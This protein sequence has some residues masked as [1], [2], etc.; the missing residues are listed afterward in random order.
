MSKKLYLIRHAKSS[1][2]DPS[3][4]D[5]DRPLNK[6]GKRDAPF[7][8][9]ILKE[10]NILPDIMISSTAERAIEFAKVLAEELDYRKKDILADKEM[11]MAGESEML[12]ILQRVDDKN[13]T[14]FMVGHNPYITSF[15]VRLSGYPIDNIPT[16][17]IVGISFDID[18]WSEAEIG[19][20][21]FL[22]F[23][24]PK[25]YSQE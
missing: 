7:M 16:S 11:Y 24:Y 8:A 3:I 21:K 18:N 19:K 6:R 13:D 20:G 10:K 15:A 2:D 23:D 14:V 4:R 17:G 1:W 9:K 12:G 22:S 5:H 25:K